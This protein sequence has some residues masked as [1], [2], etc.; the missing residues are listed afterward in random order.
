MK[1]GQVFVRAK[2][3]NGTW[4]SCDVLDLEAASFKVWLID[5]LVR[6][7]NPTGIAVEPGEGPELELRAAYVREKGE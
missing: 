4:A 6:S 5:M 2:L 7:G 1:R 3:P